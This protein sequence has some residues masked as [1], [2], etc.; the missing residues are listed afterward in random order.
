MENRAHWYA[1]VDEFAKGQFLNY[2]ALQTEGNSG[3]LVFFNF[4]EDDPADH[5]GVYLASKTDQETGS[6]YIYTIEG[7]TAGRVAV[8]KYAVGDPRIMGYGKLWES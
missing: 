8:R 2:S 5:V 1:S 4:D 6:T 3:D 7:N